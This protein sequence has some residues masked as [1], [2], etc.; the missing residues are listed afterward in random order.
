MGRAGGSLN[1]KPW[2]QE[3]KMF[4]GPDQGRASGLEVAKGCLN[5]KP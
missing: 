5:P 1:P 4:R 2:P 3:L